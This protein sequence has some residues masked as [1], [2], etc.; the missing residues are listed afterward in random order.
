MVASARVTAGYLNDPTL[1]ARRL[2]P[3]PDGEGLAYRTGDLVSRRPDGV[4][5]FHGRCDRMIKCR[6]YRIEPGEI[7]VVLARHPAVKEAFVFLA[8]DAASGDRLKACVVC[9]LEA[10]PSTEN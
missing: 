6:G 5:L 3:A 2:G 1:T 8:S 9:D 7:E 10:R 4:L